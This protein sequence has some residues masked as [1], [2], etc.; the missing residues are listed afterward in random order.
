MWT[1][2]EFVHHH[3]KKCYANSGGRSAR[4]IGG[5]QYL[6]LKVLNIKV[7]NYQ[8]NETIYNN[9]KILFT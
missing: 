8:Y 1:L 4:I 5:V 6:I 3:I 9:F 7:L 2:P